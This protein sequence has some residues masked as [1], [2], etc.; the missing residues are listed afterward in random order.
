[1]GPE[2]LP[3]EQRVDVMV[4]HHF[5]ACRRCGIEHPP[6]RMTGRDQLLNLHLG[7]QR[8]AALLLTSHLSRA[9]GFFSKLLRAP[10]GRLRPH[11]HS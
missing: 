8:A 11:D 10:I 3:I 5:G 2:L 9:A 4:E 7:V 1:M 6:Q